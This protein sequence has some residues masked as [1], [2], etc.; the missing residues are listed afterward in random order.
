MTNPGT[1]F[2]VAKGDHAI[3]PS[4]DDGRRQMTHA[5]DSNLARFL[6]GFSIEVMPRTAAKIRRFRDIIPTGT[7]VYVAHIEGTPIQDMVVTARR[8]RSEGFP[9]MPHFP[10]RIIKDRATLRDWIIRYRDDADIDQALLLAGGVNKPVGD[11]SDSMQLLESGLFGDAGFRRL[12][13]AGHPEGNPDIDPDGSTAGVDR[14][15]EWKQKF[16]ESTDAEMAIATQFCFDATPVIHW[17]GRLRDLGVTL[18]VHVGVAGP[19][20]LQTLIRFAV[21]CGVGQSLQVLRKRARDIRKLLTPFE[22]DDFLNA[23]ADYNAGCPESGIEAVHFFP[24][25]GIMACTDWVAAHREA[26]AAG[27]LATRK[28]TT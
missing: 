25:G 20:K 22:P 16:S 10:A 11:F 26:G 15:L 1:D 9:V 18:P 6:E 23:L 7:R 24:L 17:L 12:H 27:E 8:I 2:T 21:T 5:P 19:A 4:I 13:V 3:S 14:A 28:E